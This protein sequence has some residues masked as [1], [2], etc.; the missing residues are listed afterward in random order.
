MVASYGTWGYPVRAYR[1]QGAMSVMFPISMAPAPHSSISE[2]LLP[3]TFS[4]LRRILG[5]WDLVNPL[6]RMNEAW[7]GECAVRLQPLVTQYKN[8]DN[9]KLSLQKKFRDLIV[10]T[11]SCPGDKKIFIKKIFSQVDTTTIL[12]IFSIVSFS[13]KNICLLDLILYRAEPDIFT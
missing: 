2:G 7:M 1:C 3:S 8:P 13:V 4:S 11:R 6:L 5:S 10:T 12:S 9:V